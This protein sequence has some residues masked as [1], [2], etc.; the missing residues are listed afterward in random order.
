MLGPLVPTDRTVPFPSYEKETT[1]TKMPDR[2]RVVTG[3]VDTHSELHVAAVIDEVGRV[4]G[5]ETFEASARGYGRLL[6]WMRSFG[7]LAKVGVEGTG[8][9]GAGLDRYL[10]AQGVRV[11]E[12]VR[13]NRQKRRQRGKSD[14]VDAEEAARAALNGEACGASK[15]KAGTV[16]S[17]RALRVARRGAVK[18]RTQAANSIAALV[19]SA[20]SEL[21][22]RLQGLP[23]EKRM[24]LAARF[25]PGPPTD[26]AEATKAAL[27]FIARRYQELDAEIAPP[28]RHHGV[29]RRR[30]RCRG[31][32]RQ[33]RRRSTGGD[34]A[35]GH[36]G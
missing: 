32:G 9:Y 12:V 33:A 28:G 24:E 8:S 15:T 26:P 3:G 7:E 25:R 18:A 13:P 19:V 30:G 2:A 6:A 4:L 14:L 20:P 17:L 10:S 23:T 11:V 29:A 1:V 21:R 34:S 22:A 27:R 31:A 16:E 36:R 5:T 35:A